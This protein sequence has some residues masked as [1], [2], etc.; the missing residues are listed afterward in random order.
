MIKI[1][2][3]LFGN[4]KRFVHVDRLDES[5]IIEMQKDSTVNDMIHELDIDL[6][7]TKVIMVNGRPRGLEYK[8]K[9]D[10]IVAVFPAIV[11]G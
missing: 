5:G 10:D 4:L 1:H 9:Q 11:G 8:L 3:K 2:L 6:N 7:E